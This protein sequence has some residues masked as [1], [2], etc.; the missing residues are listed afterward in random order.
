MQ[1]NAAPICRHCELFIRP[2]EPRWT[3]R[4]PDEFWHYDCALKAGHKNPNPFDPARG[5]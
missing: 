4:E 2:N 5:I 3:A 1:N